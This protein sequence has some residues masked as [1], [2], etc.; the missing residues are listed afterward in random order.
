MKKF[1]S[2][3]AAVLFAGS[4]MAI[5]FTLSSA[6]EVTKSGV[7]VT[8]DKG[9][10]NNAP[11]WYD[12][13]LR[14]YASNTVTISSESTITGITFNWEK[15][16]TKAFNTA[17]ASVGEYSH[18]SAAGNG[19]W[20]GSANEVTFT[21]GASGQLLLNTFSVTIDG[22]EG[23]EGGEGGEEE[24]DE[25]CSVSG[26]G[27]WAFVEAYYDFYNDG[28]VDINL[29]TTA[30]WYFDEEGNLYGEGAGAAVVFDII[31][32]DQSD[33]AGT[34][35]VANDKLD[36]NYCYIVEYAS[37]DD[38]EGTSHEIVDGSVV[39]SLNTE[40]TAYNLV[41][42]LKFDDESEASGVVEGLCLIGGEGEEQ[43]VANV[44]ADNKTVKVLR[45]GQLIIKKNG[46]EYDAAGKIVK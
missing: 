21:L 19:V 31:P 40:G 20:T 38:E 43:A 11:A 23:G 8:F 4:M 15:Q 14:L 12:N 34:Y 28:S 26:T 7:T 41:Y 37:A 30:G 29:F 25:V 1:F 6:A 35:T 10:G 22:E 44:A 17:T 45:N 32:E 24:E 42:S 3:I 5:D 46:A 27:T 9:D 39:I 16:G 13:G 33:L 2:L 36:P 18:P